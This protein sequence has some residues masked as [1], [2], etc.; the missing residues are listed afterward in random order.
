MKRHKPSR[1]AEYMAYFRALESG[2]PG[3][4]RLFY[5]PFAPEFLGPMFRTATAIAR[6]PAFA[7]LVY[8]YTDLRLPGA[9]TSA[10]ARTR[11]IDDSLLDALYAGISQVVILGA[12]FDC[13]AYR[14]PQLAAATVFEV[15]HPATHATK[16]AR[17]RNVLTKL[18]GN[19]RHVPIDFMHESLPD[20]LG[21]AG[22]AMPQ[23]AFFIW[24]GVTQYLTPAA[25]DA[26]LNF[27]ARCSPGSRLVFTYIHAALLDGSISF[28]AAGRLLRRFARLGEPWVFGLDPEKVPEFLQQ[29]GLQLDRDLAAREYR[30]LCYQP[31]S[32]GLS[33]YE[34]YH[35]VEAQ[36]R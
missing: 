31:S 17:L 16:L 29:R 23:P 36:V 14:M 11:L 2:R 4:Q 18:P 7:P 27:V 30:A 15:D 28:K 1:T 22:F 26:V 20:V 35:V 19:V 33:G 9:R 13:R 32:Q 5:D 10:I 6:F 8:A 21:R 25:V 12:G 24:E 34:F 3:A